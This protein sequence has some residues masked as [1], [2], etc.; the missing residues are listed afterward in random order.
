MLLPFVSCEEGALR[1]FGSEKA[2]KRSGSFD[3]QADR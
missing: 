3:V 2:S 1:V